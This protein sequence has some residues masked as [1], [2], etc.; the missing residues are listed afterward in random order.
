[1]SRLT[2][3]EAAGTVSFDAEII[4][5]QKVFSFHKLCE[6]AEGEPIADAFNPGKQLLNA[7]GKLPISTVTN[8]FCVLSNLGLLVLSVG[9]AD[10][11]LKD[12]TKD[13]SY[14][15][16]LEELNIA[17]VKY[18]KQLKAKTQKPDPK[19]L[20]FL[21]SC[22]FTAAAVQLK[23]YQKLHRNKIAPKN[24]SPTKSEADKISW[25]YLPAN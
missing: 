23:K 22:G 21:A 6:L 19:T 16:K 20:R 7:N 18:G 13:T 11:T 10:K 25:G 4:A 24:K 8:M 14:E 3:N 2:T 5:R 15:K 17:I 1:V 9:P 12:I